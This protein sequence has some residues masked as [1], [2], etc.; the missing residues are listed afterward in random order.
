MVETLKDKGDM[1]RKVLYFIFTEVTKYK[2]RSKV[3]PEK[4]WDNLWKLNNQ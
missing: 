3:S 4:N 1:M 2:E